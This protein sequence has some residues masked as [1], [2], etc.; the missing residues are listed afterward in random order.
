MK[1]SKSFAA[2][3]CLLLLSSQQ[4]L[5][6]GE[7]GHHM[8]CEISTRFVREPELQ[9]FLLRRGDTLGHVCNLPDTSWRSLGPVAES[10]N[11]AHFMN[12]EEGGVS[13]SQAPTSVIEYLA[14]LKTN[15]SL[16]AKADTMGTLWWRAQQLYKDAV[17]AGASLSTV[18]PPDNDHSQDKTNPYNKAVFTFISRLGLM[19]HFVGDASMPFHNSSDYDGWQSGHGGIHS[20]YESDCVSFYDSALAQEVAAAVTELR[21]GTLVS[22]PARLTV[23][24]DEPTAVA[25]A[26]SVVD[27]IKVVSVASFSEKKQV[28][29]LDAVLEKSSLTND[30]AGKPVKVYA[31]RKP[32]GDACPAFRTLIVKELARSVSLMADLIDRAYVDAG[33]PNLKSYKAYTYPLDLDFVPLNYL[34]QN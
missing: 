32:Y 2:L 9:K 10:G 15:D 21:K 7:R 20:F 13:V 5:A 24:R 6:W 17:D 14:L 8:I 1:L 12:S 27:L 31:K 34:N 3:F 25:A 22:R 30:K 4:A 19:G 26:T 11:A 18:Q 29:D 16:Q 28:E 33:R 23:L